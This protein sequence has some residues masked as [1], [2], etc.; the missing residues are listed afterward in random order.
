[1]LHRNDLPETVNFERRLEPAGY[2]QFCHS[3]SRSFLSKFRW[4]SRES[5]SD[6]IQ[7]WPRYR[8]RVRLPLRRK[9]GSRVLLS[10]DA[11]KIAARVGLEVDRKI[12]QIG[13]MSAT[14]IG[15][16]RAKLRMAR[17]SA[18]KC[19]C[20]QRVN[21]VGFRPIRYIEILWVKKVRS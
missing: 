19:R 18:G 1:M 11:S 8:L 7:N 5:F 14:S 10:E 20:R 13:R 21:F 9:G 6:K 2:D 3:Q 16:Y 4:R 17:R 15:I 12:W